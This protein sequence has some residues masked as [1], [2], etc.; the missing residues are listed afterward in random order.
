[1]Y[2]VSFGD[3]FCFIITLLASKIRS[4]NINEGKKVKIETVFLANKTD[5][6]TDRMASQAVCFPTFYG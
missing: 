1:M 6:K 4:N 2:F 3:I 5:K